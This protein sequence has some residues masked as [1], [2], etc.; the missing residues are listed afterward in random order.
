MIEYNYKY[1]IKYYYNILMLYDKI[2]NFNYISDSTIY[3]KF[4]IIFNILYFTFSYFSELYTE[5]YC[6]NINAQLLSIYHHFIM[7]FICFGIFAPF[8]ILNIIILIN[9]ICLFLWIINKNR[10]IVTIVGNLLCGRNKYHRF[11]DLTYFLSKKFDKYFIIIRIHL[12]IFLTILM[13][14]RY[15]IG[16]KIEIHGHRGARGNFPENTLKAFSYAVENNIDVLELDT[17]ITKDKEIIIYH[18]K[19]IN[20]LICD[21][22]SYPIKELTLNQIKNYDCGGK[23]NPDFPEQQ[24]IDGEKIPTLKELFE[25]LN[26]KYKF[27][28]IKLNIEIKTEPDIDSNE[29]VIEFSNKLIDLI[30][31]Y[32]LKNRVIIQSFDIRA[33]YAI[34]NIDKSIITSYLIEDGNIHEKIETSKELNVEI[35]S[36]DYKLLNKEIINEIHKNNAKVIPWTVNTIEDLKIMIDYNVDGIITDYP[37]EMKNY[38]SNNN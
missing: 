3:V 26:T 24:T 30:N 29:E 37:V 4:Y 21:G 15:S 25:L 2:R 36:P 6:S 7:Y 9:I 35:I 32:G 34:K 38:I 10:C 23:K 19:N 13:I 5:K 16:K 8:S 12:F 20:N 22:T 33:L 11:Q 18:D 1:I 31:N 28:N 17:Q 27:S 14:V